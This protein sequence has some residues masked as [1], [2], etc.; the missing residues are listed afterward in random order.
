MRNFAE[1][2][3]TPVLHLNS[4]DPR[5]ILRVRLPLKV[6]SAAGQRA[7]GRTLTAPYYGWVLVGALG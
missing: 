5:H 2:N 3:A 6:A 1:T 7:T 4:P